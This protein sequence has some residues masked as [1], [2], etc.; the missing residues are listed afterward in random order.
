[1]TK[2]RSIFANMSW[3]MASQ[4]LTSIL[5]FFWTII[6]IRYLGVSNNGIFGNAVSF[7][8]LFVIIADFG[9]T[10]YITRAISTDYDLEESYIGN[11]ITIKIILSFVYLALT[12]IIVNLLGWNNRIG[13]IIFL[14]AFESVIKS[15]CNL[16][17]TSFQAHEKIKYQA[18]SNIIL[19]V[20]TFIFII[21]VTFTSFGLFGIAIAYILANIITLIYTYLALKRYFTSP[22]LLFDKNLSK[23]L[24]IAGIPFALTSL[25]YTI[26]YSID[27]VML[28]K[29]IGVYPT[30]LY[31]ASYKLINVLTLFY[32]IY[33]AVVFPV[34]SKLF[35]NDRNLL[36]LSFNKSV[37]Y[38]SL[39]TIPLAVATLFYASDVIFLFCGNEFIKADDVL[40]IL[41][42]TVCFLFINGAASLV[43]N[44]SHKEFSVTK[45]YSIAAIFNV[46]LNFILIP[47]YSVYGASV[48]TVLSEILILIL[49][50]YMLSKINQLPNRH[51]VFDLLKIIIASIIMGVAL[52]ILG[53]NVWIA[54]PVGIII[55]L[56]VIIAIKIADDDD[57]MILRQL[58]NK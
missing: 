21:L 33:S 32:T 14:F 48:A 54:I 36:T 51:L 58:I 23:K 4:I 13:F 55:Y 29:F 56:V 37:K 22:K 44:A 57:K 43:L 49:E 42:W 53:L 50:L 35:K 17:Y 46:V 1:M 41:I 12:F 40:K 11:A 19:N 7:A 26:Y 27:M 30:G 9:M 28:T 24:I 8:N 20:L 45:I 5:A 15:F 25:F 47:H 31:N 16:F 18:I 3:L 52:Y 6:T 10:T 38:L 39:I 2:V 34:M